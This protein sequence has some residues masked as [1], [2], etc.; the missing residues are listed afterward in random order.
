MSKSGSPGFVRYAE[1][2]MRLSALQAELD[3]EIELRR[4]AFRALIID[5]PDARASENL[6][7]IFSY[8]RHRAAHG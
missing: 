6:A 3:Q 1:T 7:H 8:H 2:F 5:P 4:H